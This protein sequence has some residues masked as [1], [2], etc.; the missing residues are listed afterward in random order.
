V[1]DQPGID[2]QEYARGDPVPVDLADGFS[3]FELKHHY[4][5]E[6]FGRKRF[7]FAVGEIYRGSFGVDDQA[8]GSERGFQ[9]FDGILAGQGESSGDLVSEILQDVD[10]HAAEQVFLVPEVLVDQANADPGLIRDRLHGDGVKA[11]LLHEIRRGS[12]Y[13]TPSSTDPRLH[14]GHPIRLLDI[15]CRVSHCPHHYPQFRKE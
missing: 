2:V 9:A 10:D 11:R 5:G 7:A 6:A 4:L 8:A 3:G 15:Q 13:L 1:G 14:P 12:E